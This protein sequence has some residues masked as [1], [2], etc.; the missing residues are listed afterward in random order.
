MADNTI[1]QYVSTHTGTEIDT[2]VD[3]ITAIQSDLVDDSTLG[4]TTIKTVRKSLY[5]LNSKVLK[6]STNSDAIETRFGTVEY[7]ITHN[8][9]AISDVSQALT[10]LQNDNVTKNTKKIEGLEKAVAD[11]V[12]Q[13]EYE[14]RTDAIIGSKTKLTNNELESK[15][16]TLYQLKNAIDNTN[17]NIPCNLINDFSNCQ[18]TV[19]SHTT[20]ISSLEKRTLNLEEKANKIDSNTNNISRLENALNSQQTVIT[21]IQGN[22]NTIQENVSTIQGNYISTDDFNV[23]IEVLNSQIEVLNSQIKALNSEIKDLKSRVSTLESPSSQE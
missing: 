17:K 19:Q 3:K 14:G 21:E 12:A 10:A 5:D 6:L 9:Q 13:E 4:N 2:A 20:K 11:K 23:Q 1:T 15:G 7:N 16:M 22:I 18:S 8:Q